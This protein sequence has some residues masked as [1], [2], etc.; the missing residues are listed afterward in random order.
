[1]HRPIGK[2]DRDM[3]RA[4]HGAEQQLVH[5]HKTLWSRRLQDA[6]NRHQYWVLWRTQF[7]TNRD[8]SNQRNRLPFISDIIPNHPIPTLAEVERQIL[9]ARKNIR[10]Q[11][12]NAE[13]LREDHLHA[14]AVQYALLKDTN[15][16]HEIK[17]I[18]RNERVRSTFRKIKRVLKPQRHNNIT[19]VLIPEGHG[20]SSVSEP[21]QMRDLLIER[22]KSH[23]NQASGS[24]FTI[25]PLSRICR[26]D[27]TISEDPPETIDSAAQQILNHIQDQQRPPLAEITSKEL[28]QGFTVWRE[29]TSTSPSG[30]HLGV[31]KALLYQHPDD[32]N[33]FCQ[34]F[35]QLLSTI[36]N[37]AIRHGYVLQR[38]RKV[39]NALLEKIPGTPRIDKFRV[40]HIFEADLNLVFGILWNR[41]L[42]RHCEQQQ[43]L[44]PDQWGSRPG[45]SSIDAAMLK[46]LTYELSS[47]TRTDH[48]TFDN[49]AK[50]CYDR[51]IPSLA[52]RVCKHYGLHQAHAHFMAS[53]L[54]QAEYTIPIPGAAL[55]SF[56]NQDDHQLFGTGQGSRASP[57]IWAMIS[58]VLLQIHRLSTR[59]TTFRNPNNQWHGISMQ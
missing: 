47:L 38:W 59:G 29:E 55:R 13:Q 23:F 11:Q 5:H 22:N 19:H 12:Q 17:R 50:A 42:M 30:H 31:Y 53:F 46:R 9:A 8:L 58:D 48:G 28:I 39:T 37:Q 1:M 41:R 49:D 35:Y 16:L 52:M 10:Q 57:T 32:D 4:I 6:K 36:I 24:P 44:G 2:I 3:T 54:R 25:E 33:P 34:E 27:G 20:W 14:L 45:R 7:R 26:W 15:P 21:N 43:T 18:Q 51:I 56:T 40:I